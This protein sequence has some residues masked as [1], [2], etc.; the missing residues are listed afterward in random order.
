MTDTNPTETNIEIPVMASVPQESSID[1][2]IEIEQID[3]EIQLDSQPN[4]PPAPVLTAEEMRLAKLC[5][6]CQLVDW[7]YTCPRCHTHSCSMTCVKRH[8]QDSDCSGIR[9]KTSYV[10][11]H[12]YNES[13]MMSGKFY[14]RQNTAEKAKLLYFYRLYIFRRCFETIR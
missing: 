11:L 2:S 12:K 4:I 14:L 5:Q 9:D 6:V 10:P 1:P 3:P 8:K 13:N 7:K